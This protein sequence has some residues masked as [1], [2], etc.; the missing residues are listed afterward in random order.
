MKLSLKP[1]VKR[2]LLLALTSVAVAPQVACEATLEDVAGAGSGGNQLPGLSGSGGSGFGAGPGGAGVVGG[3]AGGSGNPFDAGGGTG[4]GGANVTGDCTAGIVP[5]DVQALIV[6]RCIA[7]HGN[8][9]AQDV[10]ASLTSFAELTARSKSDPTKTNAQ[11]ALARLQDS[12]KPM[13]PAPLSRA[14]AA[15]IAALQ[16][17]VAAGTPKGT[18]PDGGVP[19]GGGADG[20]AGFDVGPIV[21]PFAAAPVCTSNRMWTNGN[22]GSQQMNPGRGCIACHS[23]GRGPG[24]SV[25]GTLYPTAHEPDLC[26]GVNGTTARAQIVIVGANGQ[27]VTLTPNSAGNFDSSTNIMKPYKAKVVY[28]GRERAMIT[29][30]TSGDCNSCHTQN[31]AMPT[32]TMK[33]PGR[34]LLP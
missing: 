14:S 23:M 30:Q 1:L 20:G 21:D 18:C 15:E 16:K 4:T 7:C 26:N 11:L 10:P 19:D 33:A 13:P 25:A 24:F 2:S 5:A 27:Q 29:A 31:G 22:S 9:P 12:T 3:G 34:I 17:W 6:N 28:M 32:G 8:P